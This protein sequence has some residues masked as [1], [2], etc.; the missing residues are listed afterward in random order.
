MT[1][2]VAQLA[3]ILTSPSP[4]AL[5]TFFKEQDCRKVAT[6]LE[7]SKTMKVR[8]NKQYQDLVQWQMSK[9]RALLKIPC[10]QY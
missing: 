10:Y 9:V 3:S 1:D 4:K 8:D 5:E 7:L 6:L 2:P